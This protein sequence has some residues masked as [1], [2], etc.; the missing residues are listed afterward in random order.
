MKDKMYT[1]RMKSLREVREALQVNGQPESYYSEL[2]RREGELE[3]RRR[4]M[5]HSTINTVLALAAL[6]KSIIMV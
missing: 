6:A 2:I 4:F 1:G 3:E 5:I